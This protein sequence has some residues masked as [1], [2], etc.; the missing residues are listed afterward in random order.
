MT[1]AR[2]ASRPGSGILL[3][4]SWSVFIV[5]VFDP[6]GCMMI[7]LSSW[8]SA[9][10]AGARKSSKDTLSDEPII[11][12]VCILLGLV[13]PGFDIQLLTKLLAYNIILF[14]ASA[15][16]SFLRH[17]LLITSGTYFDVS[18]FFCGVMS[19]ISCG[20]CCT[21]VPSSALVFV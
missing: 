11:E 6:F 10:F 4:M 9:V 2:C 20:A 18:A 15:Q 16:K 3:R 1:D 19:W 7:L 8:M 13:H 17:P 21:V 5:F 12:F 14:S